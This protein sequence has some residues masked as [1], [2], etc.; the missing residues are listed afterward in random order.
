MPTYQE[1]GIEG[2]V[3]EQWLGVFVPAGTP[4]VIVAR[5]NADI[6]KALSEVAIREGFLH[7]A[8][9]SVGGS[10]EAFSQLVHRDFET[11]GRLLK[12]LNIKPE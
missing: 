9:E 11:Y 3:L 12:E 5:L 2:L 1:G 4:S 7:S 8:Q 6:N 10:A